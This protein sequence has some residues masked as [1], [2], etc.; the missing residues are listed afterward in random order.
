M[1]GSLRMRYL[2]Q[3]LQDWAAAFAMT[4]FVFAI[5]LFAS[6]LA[7]EILIRRAGQ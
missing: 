3:H 7:E 2:K 6:G 1:K 5:F 4:A